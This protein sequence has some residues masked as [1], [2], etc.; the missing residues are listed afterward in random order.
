M[1][2][3]FFGRSRG[4]RVRARGPQDVQGRAAPAL[5]F[6]D[7]GEGAGFG[8][9]QQR[10]T[11]GA[12]N[13]LARDGENLCS[14]VRLNPSEPLPVRPVAGRRGRAPP[15]VL[16]SRSRRLGC[17]KHPAPASKG[18]GSSGIGRRF[19]KGYAPLLC[20]A[21]PTTRPPSNSPWGRS[22]RPP[23]QAS[24]SPPGT[25]SEGARP[26]CGSRPFRPSPDRPGRRR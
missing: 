26:R 17:G 19:A 20:G 16:R 9:E 14:H 1:L 2:V 10:R 4:D 22:A 6:D 25:A 11:A 24:R 8:F 18:E 3:P 7:A 12:A 13:R 15:D 23:R 21:V 5:D